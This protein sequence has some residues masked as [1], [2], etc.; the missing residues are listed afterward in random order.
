M[1][2]N[3][4]TR[5]GYVVNVVQVDTSN[6]VMTVLVTN[7]EGKASG[8]HIFNLATMPGADPSQICREAY[9]IAFEESLP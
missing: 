7:L 2:L 6:L 1:S 8:R 9:P 4:Q 5:Q 3:L